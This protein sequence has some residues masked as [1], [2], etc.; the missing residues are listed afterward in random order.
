MTHFENDLFVSLIS[1][2]RRT[3]FVRLKEIRAK[4]SKKSSER[5]DEPQPQPKKV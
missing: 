1:F 3:F 2:P 4:V 5:T